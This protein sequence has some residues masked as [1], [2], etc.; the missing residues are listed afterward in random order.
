MEFQESHS[1]AFKEAYSS[2]FFK[3]VSAFSNECEGKDVKII[4]YFPL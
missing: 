1:M 4:C 3:I 2:S